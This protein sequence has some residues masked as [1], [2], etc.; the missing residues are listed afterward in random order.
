MSEHYKVD[1]KNHITRFMKINAT[2][3][4]PSKKELVVC[5]QQLRKIFEKSVKEM[6]EIK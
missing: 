2:E 5:K 1:W 6:M 4:K 3:E